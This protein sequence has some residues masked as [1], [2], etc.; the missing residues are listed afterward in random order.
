MLP[1][2]LLLPQGYVDRLDIRQTERAIAPLKRT[3]EAH[4]AANLNLSRVSAPL[5]VSKASGLNDNLSG[6]ERPVAFCVPGLG[7]EACEVVQSLAKWK[8]MAL[9]RYGFAP[10]EGLYTDMNALRADETR[11]DNIHSVYVDQWDW[12][13]VITPAQRSLDTLKDTVRAIYAAIVATQ[14]ALAAEYPQLQAYL[15][16][17]ITFIHSQDLLNEFPGL[18]AD[19]REDAA[20]RKYGAVFIIGI[21]GPLSDGLSHDDRAPDYDDW[22]L[23]GDLL[24][25]YPVLGRA[26]ELQSMGVRVDA[27]TLQAQL[28]AKAQ[29][30]C[31]ELPFHR[32]LINGELPQT[33][34]G[35]IGQ[36]RMSMILLQK[37]HIGQVQASLWPQESVTALRDVGIELL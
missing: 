29:M 17:E 7:D 25:W 5:F 28:A 1:E 10:G 11:L 2:G 4:L 36:S 13:K 30:Q 26:I 15:P 21:G 22:S 16:G 34:G 35:G 23:N 6:V 8:R 24:I 9:A 31:L 3:F 12:E 18:P 14:Q 33:I 32:A 19:K 37:A 20:C 27:L